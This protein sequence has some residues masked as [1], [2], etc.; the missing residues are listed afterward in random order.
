MKIL[1]ASDCYTFQIGG[2]TNAILSL[3]N[4]LRR[5]GCQVKV[6][7]LSDTRGSRKDGENYYLRSWRFP[8]YPE[9]RISF[10]FHDSLLDE[11]A[12]WKPDIVHIHTEAT[13]GMMAKN[14]AKTQHAT[15]QQ[16]NNLFFSLFCAVGFAEGEVVDYLVEGGEVA[17]AAAVEIGYG[18]CAAAVH[19]EQ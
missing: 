13:M 4:G 17:E 5:E 2:V 3:E 1:M 6:L 8:D 18:V 7:A 19:A 12:A 15:T 9:H 11:L 10:A 16:R 14:I